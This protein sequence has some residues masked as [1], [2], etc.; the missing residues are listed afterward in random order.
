MNKFENLSQEAK[1]WAII[2]GYAGVT[3]GVCYFVYKWYA[4]LI[5]KAVVKELL[6]AGVIA[7]TMA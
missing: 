3:I 1:A 5:G 4:A 2:I 6:K 7:V